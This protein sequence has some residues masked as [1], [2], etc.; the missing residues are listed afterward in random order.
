MQFGIVVPVEQAGLVRAM[1]YDY[2]EETVPRLIGGAQAAPDEPWTGA[3]RAR[4]AA[5]PVT[6]ANMLVPASLK[7]TGPEPAAPERLRA[8]MARVTDRAAQCGIRTL[9][10]GSGAARRMPD[11]FDPKQARRQ[12]L[13]FIRMAVPFCA[14]YQIMLVCE[15]LNRG[16]CNL[17]NSVQEAM[18]YV[19]EV[20]HP[21]FQCLVDSYHFWLEDEPIEHVRDAMPWM[22]HVHVADREGR[23][24]PGLSGRSDYR[25]LF[26]EL[27][28]GHYDGTITLETIGYEPLLE[29]APAALAFL[30]RQWAEA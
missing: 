14:R 23:V 6:A 8:H 24:P 27:K 16:D 30:R 19:F 9:V 2:V 18:S 26:A 15:P 7:I 22:R 10:F 11:D 29:A 21:N 3:T 1:G 20:D 5:L 4:A 13:E 25:P 12:I 28:R 17:I